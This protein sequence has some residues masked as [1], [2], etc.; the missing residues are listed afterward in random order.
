MEWNKGRS[1]KLMGNVEQAMRHARRQKNKSDAVATVFFGLLC[2]FLDCVLEAWILL[3]FH[4]IMFETNLSAT[5]NRIQAFVRL[6]KEYN[7]LK[8]RQYN[9]SSYPPR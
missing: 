8:E 6:E 4:I 3:A 7:R 2:V 5:R 9:E 1:R